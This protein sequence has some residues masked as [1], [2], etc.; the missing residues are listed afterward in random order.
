MRTTLDIDNEVLAAAKEL[1]RCERKTAGQVLSE[2]ARRA[3]TGS[4]I[5]HK[6]EEPVS[7][8][9]FRPFAARGP[10]VTNDAIDRLRDSEGV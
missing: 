4:D 1:A 5:A 10:L 3:L 7:V 2:L 9:G 8:Y 6:A